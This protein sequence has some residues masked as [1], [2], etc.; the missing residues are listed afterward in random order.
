MGFYYIE[1]GEGRPFQGDEQDE[2]RQAQDRSS[3]PPK[4]QHQELHGVFVVRV[5][6]MVWNEARELGD[7]FYP[8]VK[9]KAEHSGERQG[10]VFSG[11]HA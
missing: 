7:T 1:R 5:L 2:K 4:N 9:H 6:G 11:L 10:H 8:A 3:Y